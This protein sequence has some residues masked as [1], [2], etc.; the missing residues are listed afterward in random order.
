M[1]ALWCGI[2]DIATRRERGQGTGR[3][4][5]RALATALSA[6]GGYPEL[7]R[8]R[9]CLALVGRDCRRGAPRFTCADKSGLDNR[10]APRPSGGPGGGLGPPFR[11]SSLGLLLPGMAPPLR[12]PVAWPLRVRTARRRNAALLSA[13]SRAR[14]ATTCVNGN[15]KM[16]RKYFRH[17]VC[18]AR[19]WCSHYHVRFF[20]HIAGTTF[21]S[22]SATNR[23]NG[24][25]TRAASGCL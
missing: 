5:L 11:G 16:V 6:P 9:R 1:Y 15:L 7:R 22:P 25:S 18:G 8:S 21:T 3:H 20:T 23:A 17:A 24:T 13:A 19:K 4:T 12:Q 10:G 2:D 14:K